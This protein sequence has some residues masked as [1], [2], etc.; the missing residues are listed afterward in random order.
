MSFVG[1]EE[2]TMVMPLSGT[3]AYSTTV[4]PEGQNA[5]PWSMKSTEP[6]EHSGNPRADRRLVGWSPLLNIREAGLPSNPGPSVPSVYRSEIQL[7]STDK[8]YASVEMVSYFL[9]RALV[10]VLKPGDILHIARTCCG[11][12]GFSALRQEKLIFAVGAVAS[13]SLG[14]HISVKIPYD[15]VRKAEA[16]FRSRDPEFES[17]HH[18]VEVCIGDCAKIWYRGLVRMRGYHVWVEHGFIP[19]V[20]GTEECVSIT[21]DKECDWVAGCASAQLLAL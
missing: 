15:L 6:V 11:G 13:V 21:L 5:F 18:P 9:D 10:R 17:A 12:V 7:V 2:L 8:E 1:E 3:F 19:D 4:P 20:P 14:S 16:I